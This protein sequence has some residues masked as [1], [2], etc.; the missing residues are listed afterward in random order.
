VKF[1]TQ[2]IGV[3]PEWR[4]YRNVRKV[5]YSNLGPGKYRFQVKAA[6]NDGVWNETPATSNFVIAPLLYQTVWFYTLCAAAILLF[7]WQLYRLRIHQVTSQVRGRLTARLEERERIARDLHDTLLQSIQ[8]LILLFQG[9]AGRLKSPDPMRVQMEAA[10]DHADQLLNEA[11]TRVGELRLTSANG[12]FTKAITRLA[13]ETFSG[14]T[15]F[16]LVISGTQRDLASTIADE[17]YSIVREA[18][19]NA[20]KHADASIVKTTIEYGAERFQV[21]IADNGKGVVEL[22]LNEGGLSGHFGLQGMRE[23]ARQI[24]GRF[25]ILSGVNG[26]IEIEVSV[27]VGVA[28]GH[29]TRRHGWIRRLRA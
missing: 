24:D 13:A 23:R 18:F 14:K 22:M 19:T 7:L 29:A 28:Y 26:G 15:Q 21:R 27:P 25:S 2:L 8:G 17:L 16:Q 20:L 11:R 1:R 9:F 10:L 4:E 12:D 6:N 3:D 5:S